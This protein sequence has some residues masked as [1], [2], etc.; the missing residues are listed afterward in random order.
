MFGTVERSPENQLIANVAKSET[1]EV[2]DAS[3]RIETNGP[4]PRRLYGALRL[5][6]MIVVGL[7]AACVCESQKPP[8]TNSQPV[9][10]IVFERNDTPDLSLASFPYVDIFVMDQ[11]GRH[12]RRITSDHR[13]HSPSW[14]PDARQIVFLSDVRSPVSPITDNDPDYAAFMQYRDFLRIPRNVVRMDADGQNSKPVA[15]G[16]TVAQDVLWFVDGRR[17]GIRTSDRLTWNVFVDT[18]GALAPNAQQTEP[19]EQYLDQGTPLPGGGYVADYSTLLEW[20][21]SMDNFSPAFVAST[22]LL[23][24][25][26]LGLI[27]NVPSAANVNLSLRAVSLEGRPEPF[28]IAAYDIA[29]SA[30]GKHIAYSTFSGNQKS[31]LY[32]AEMLPGDT[33][34]NRRALTDAALNAHGP[35]WSADSSR[36]AFM[37]LWRDSS[38]IFFIGADG[39][40]LVQVSRNAKMSCYHPS[41]SP[42]GKW[43]VADCRQSITVMSPFMA[44]LGGLSNIYLFDLTKLTSKPRQLT[45]CPPGNPIPPTCGARNASF[46]PVQSP[47]R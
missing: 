34:Q 40:N 28:Q 9:F 4:M 27:K 19:L 3:H 24:T 13:S 11:Y 31:I 32:A 7:L 30:D 6:G 5:V 37:G 41:W 2:T 33:E 25:P 46:A 15:S 45:S 39:A 8:K 22:M 12:A 29:W 20:V 26:N 10:W 17:I 44:E 38:Q 42:D 47:L 36:I 35:A 43:I 21:P 14:S 23:R 1:A 16:G 18:S